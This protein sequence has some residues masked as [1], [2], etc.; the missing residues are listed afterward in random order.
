MLITKLATVHGVRQRVRE[1]VPT[2][3]AAV[4]RTASL[5]YIRGNYLGERI[6]CPI[7]PGLDRSE[8]ALRNLGNLFV[9]LTLELTEYEHISVMLGKLGNAFLDDLPQVPLAVHVVGSRCSVL[10]LQRTILIL[11]VFLNRLEQHKRIT[12]PV[13][14]LILR[15]VRC[16]RV[17]PRR[18]LLRAVEAMEMPIDANED[19][20]YQIFR[21]L[22]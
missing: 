14:E 13:A 4:P 18:E 8:I 12:R 1:Q 16:D 19:F 5:I 6:S 20:L 3:G 9:R 2:S 11:E 21:L 7:Q 17:D 15:Q 22:S 10:E